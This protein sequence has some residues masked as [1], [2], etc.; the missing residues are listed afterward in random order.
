MRKIKLLFSAYRLYKGRTFTLQPAEVKMIV[1]ESF[2]IARSSIWGANHICLKKPRIY[3]NTKFRTYNGKAIGKFF[4]SKRLGEIHL[5]AS[6]K[7]LSKDKHDII[8]TLLH[9][10][11]HIIQFRIGNKMG[12]RRDFKLI[13]KKLLDASTYFRSCCS[14]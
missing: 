10:L 14:K 13:E 9:E 3:W 2:K 11:G 5:N 12:H 4:G 1:R 7:H 8:K 6:K